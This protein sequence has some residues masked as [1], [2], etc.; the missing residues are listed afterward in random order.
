M[1]NV[2]DLGRCN[3]QWLRFAT[4]FFNNKLVPVAARSEV[5]VAL[6]YSNPGI[7]GSNPA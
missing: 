5:G 1:S 2:L 3:V 6:D 7:V 4:F